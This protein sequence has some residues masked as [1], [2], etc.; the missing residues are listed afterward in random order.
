MPDLVIYGKIITDDIQLQDGSIARGSPSGVGA[1]LWNDSVGLLSR[2]SG[3]AIDGTPSR[4][5]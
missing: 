4:R 3:P 2:A 5:R 1:R